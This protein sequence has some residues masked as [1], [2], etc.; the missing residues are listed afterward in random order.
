MDTE[1]TKMNNRNLEQYRQQVEAEHE[2]IKKIVVAYLDHLGR[3]E[4]DY[5]Q[6]MSE[7]SKRNLL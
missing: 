2:R 7:L 4:D 3:L 6:V 1:I 5:S